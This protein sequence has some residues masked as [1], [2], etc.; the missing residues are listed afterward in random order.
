MDKQNFDDKIV[1][2]AK[3]VF[4]Y[5]MS[6]TNDRIE[7]E[8]LSQN[9]LLEII[10][11]VDNIRDDKAFYGFMWGIAGNVYKNWCKTKSA[12]KNCEFDENISD[13]CKSFEKSIEQ[14]VELNLLRRELCLLS[15]KYR[16]ATIMYYVQNKS[17]AEISDAL[18]ISES[19]AKYLLFK[20][21]EILKE[22]IDMDRQYGEQSYNPKNLT[23][24]FLGD[25]KNQYYN[26]CKKKIPQNILIACYNDR[27]TI[28]EISLQI[29]V[30]IPYLEDEINILI[31]HDVL[32]KKGNKYYTNIVIFTDEFIKEVTNKAKP[33]QKEIAKI[34]EE[35]LVENEEK[36]RNIG[37]YGCD[38]SH[39]TYMWQMMCLILYRA[40]IVKLQNNINI[41]YPKTIFGDNAF[42][43][44][45]QIDYHNNKWGFGICT[46]A[47]KDDDCM[48]FMDYVGNGKMRH[49]EFYD[50]PQL[51]NIYFDIAKGQID[52]FSEYEL[53][54]VA[55]LVKKGYVL[56]S[57]NK[58]SVTVPVY[59]KSEF[60]ELTNIIDIISN[61]VYE[62]AL[63]LLDLIKEVL[64]NHTPT[65]LKEQAKSMAW[66]RLFDDAISQPS[67]FMYNDNYIKDVESTTELP[68]TYIRLSK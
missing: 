23:L 37:F 17:C 25:G 39:N 44:G 13:N 16:K 49:M 5:C 32:K 58:F 35:F 38:M 50:K 54:I 31:E 62:K 46:V 52:K 64:E 47:S 15:E 34:A 21:R 2:V 55:E 56:N 28:E 48:Q 7:A 27:L 65:H 8:D 18:D 40:I 1:N 4:S 43:W 24:L 9:I 11:S 42:V 45:T 3:T 20:A 60:D 30:P 19:M 26:L 53:E 59:T 41:E 67:S 66:L 61:S 14:Q 51:T 6:R 12:N 22:G 63:C 68:T 57:D 10:K 29:G 33:I 36:I